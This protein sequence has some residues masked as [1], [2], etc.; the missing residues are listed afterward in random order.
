MN[1]KFNDKDPREKT[2]VGIASQATKVFF[3][4][5]KLRGKVTIRHVLLKHV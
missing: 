4:C 2:N 5:E 1:F 3:F